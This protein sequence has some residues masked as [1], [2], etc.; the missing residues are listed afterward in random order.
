LGLT[1]AIDY[2]I[3]SLR[4]AGALT[5]VLDAFKSA[6]KPVHLI[7]R[8]GTHVPLKTRAFL[9]YATARLKKAFR[10]LAA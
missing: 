3:D 2:Q 4:R 1:R 7:Y 8:G 10:A 6:P 9:D 5:L